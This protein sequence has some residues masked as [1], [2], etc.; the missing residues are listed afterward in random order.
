[1][2]STEFEAEYLG[3]KTWKLWSRSNRI[4]MSQR[5]TNSHASKFE[6]GCGVIVAG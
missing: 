6:V 4:S 2:Y 3:K 5:P 1:M